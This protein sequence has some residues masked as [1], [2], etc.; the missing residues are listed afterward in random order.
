MDLTNK[1]NLYHV[2]NATDT[3]KLSGEITIQSTGRVSINGQ[4]N[5]VASPAKSLSFNYYEESVDRINRSYNGSADIQDAANTLVD[6]TIAAVKAEK[7]KEA[8][9]EK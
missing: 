9:D 3:V 6:S 1:R 8:A 7:A 2:E 4:I 5:T